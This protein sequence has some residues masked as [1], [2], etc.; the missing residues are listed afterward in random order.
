[1][2]NAKLLYNT[3]VS[4]GRNSGAEY[5]TSFSNRSDSHKSSLGFLVTAETYFG[6]NGYSMRFDGQ[7]NFINTNVRSRDIVMHGSRYVNSQRADEGSMMGR[8]YGC[9]A[10]P[11]SECD[12]IID[13]IKRRKLLFYLQQR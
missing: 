1:M 8:S 12:D 6:K 13:C 5:A 4:H 9:P 2:A 7:E 11:Y 10:I 3:Y